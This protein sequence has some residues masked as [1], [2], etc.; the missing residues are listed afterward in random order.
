MDNKLGVPQFGLSDTT[1]VQ[2]EACGN[3]VFEQALILR[4]VSPILTGN[5]QPGIVPVP[6]FICSKCGHVN[7]EFLPR[8]LQSD[9]QS[10]L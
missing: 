8:E 1:A 4:K 10:K 3:E 5:G 7:K 2:C 6:V 9:E